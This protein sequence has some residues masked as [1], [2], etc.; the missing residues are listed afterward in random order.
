MF[1]AMKIS[2]GFWDESFPP[3]VFVSPKCF[4][5]FKGTIFW[6]EMMVVL[7]VPSLKETFGAVLKNKMFFL[8]PSL[9]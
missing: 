1:L 7:F 3:N 9:S 2:W 8:V 5:F 6:A 4:F